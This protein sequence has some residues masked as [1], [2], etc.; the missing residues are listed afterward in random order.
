MWFRRAFRTWFLSA[1][2]CMG[3]LAVWVAAAQLAV[4]RTAHLMHN[5]LDVSLAF[6]ALF[7]A[8]AAA[9]Y[10]PVFSLLESV[11]R[12]RLSRS[13]ASAVGAGLA[14]VAYLGVAWRFREAEDP[15][16]VTAWLTYCAARLPELAIGILPFAAAG[17]LFGLLWSRRDDVRT[18]ERRAERAV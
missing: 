7:A 12:R 3:L 18:I 13:V 11:L 9:V 5:M 2:A 8:A 10:V 6:G 17:A 1:L 14:P 16:T 15:H 4:G